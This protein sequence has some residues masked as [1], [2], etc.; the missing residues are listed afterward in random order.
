M[1]FQ[2]KATGA[3]V[4]AIHPAEGEFVGE[5]RA[6]VGDWLVE[7]PDGRKELVGPQAFVDRFEYVS[8]AG[9]D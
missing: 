8:A 5:D 2:E 9:P 4:K 1:T 3:Q 7:W 6:Q